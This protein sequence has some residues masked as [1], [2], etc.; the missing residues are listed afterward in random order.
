MQKT[1]KKDFYVEYLQNFITIN[2]KE[3]KPKRKLN[4][5]EIFMVI[6]LLRIIG[7]KEFDIKKFYN[8]TEKLNN[9]NLVQKKYN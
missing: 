8:L 6:G 1:D 7:A 5:Q 2:K 4:I 9:N 3:Y